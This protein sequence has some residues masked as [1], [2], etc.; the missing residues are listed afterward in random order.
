MF[1]RE[2][3]WFSGGSFGGLRVDRPKTVKIKSY[4]VSSGL[5]TKHQK[6]LGTK[7]F[8]E[9]GRGSPF[10]LNHHLRRLRCEPSRASILE[11]FWTSKKKPF[12]KNIPESVPLAQNTQYSWW[13]GQLKAPQTSP[14]IF[15][16]TTKP[17][18][19][20]EEHNYTNIDP[21]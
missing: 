2:L 12:K 13:F 1:I 7:V 11:S 5:R 18:K 14:N 17:Q 9:G 16:Q 19:H 21:R 10:A 4:E 8:G 3:K 15:W 20:P 6:I